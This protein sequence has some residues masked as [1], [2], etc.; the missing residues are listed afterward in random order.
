MSSA[1]AGKS[2]NCAYSGPR[3][4]KDFR[5]HSD[6]DLLV[7]LA[8]DAEWSLLDHVAMEEELAGIVGAK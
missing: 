4:A 3:C 8:P 5:P 2:S 1:A 6:L 7:R